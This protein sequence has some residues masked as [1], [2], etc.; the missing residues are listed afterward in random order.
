MAVNS[1]CLV[2]STLHDTVTS[3][4]S[5]VSR[6]CLIH[7]DPPSHYFILA[8]LSRYQFLKDFDRSDRW[9]FNRFF[10]ILYFSK[11]DSVG[12]EAGRHAE[13]Y[14]PLPSSLY[15]FLSYREHLHDVGCVSR[16]DFGQRSKVDA[17]R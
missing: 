4:Y 1:L 12:F 3:I 9:D 6:F 14:R 10:F 16:V 17:P 15:T 7:D 8:S 5:S 13:G 11:P 2:P